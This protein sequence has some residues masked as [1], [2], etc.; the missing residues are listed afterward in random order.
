MRLLLDTHALIWFVTGDEKLSG[1]AKNAILDPRNDCLF[2]VAS[3]W[4]MSIKISIGK[5]TLA[6]SEKAFERKL[7]ENDIGLL[8]IT[9]AHTQATRSLP[10]HHRD[11]FDRML[12]AQAMTEKLT[13]VSADAEFTK[14]PIKLLW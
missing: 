11:P 10:F 13:L 14:Y 7:K 8:T 12:I 4:E 1:S 3:F 9:I 2:S 6:I 5:F